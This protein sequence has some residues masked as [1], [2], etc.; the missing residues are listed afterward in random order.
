[1][2]DVNVTCYTHDE[3]KRATQIT[4]SA[5]GNWG[6]K[7]SCEKL[8]KLL[9]FA[10][11]TKFLDEIM[12]RIPWEW[13]LFM[14]HLERV[15]YSLKYGMDE[16]AVPIP[17]IFDEIC[18]D[19]TGEGFQEKMETNKENLSFHEGYFIIK[20]QTVEAAFDLERRK[21]ISCIAEVLKNQQK[22]Q[23]I[24][25]VGEF[26]KSYI[27]Q[28]AL[29]G[30]FGESRTIHIPCSPEVAVIEGGLLL[31]HNLWDIERITPKW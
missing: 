2:D 7:H 31:G 3:W 13:S 27:L 24:L 12:H 11:G 8:M 28:N 5:G 15:P 30:V 14:E 1:M 17:L 18:K 9:S 6:P 23:H 26:G 25:L 19:L 16:V 22:S 20:L 4:R 29:K 21:I 10:I